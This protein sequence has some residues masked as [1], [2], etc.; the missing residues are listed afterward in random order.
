MKRAMALADLLPDLEIPRE[1]VVRGLVQDSRSVEPG[2]AFVAIG[3]FG[4][5]GL[6]FVGQARENGA[7]A[8]LFEPPI[9]SELQAP[10]DAIAVPGLRARLGAMADQF[11]ARPSRAL[12]MVGVTGTNGKTS[13]VQL[14]AQAWHVR[15]VRAGSIGTLGA[16]LYGEAVPTGFTTPLV[17]QLHALL[18]QLRDAG[19]DAVAMEVSSHALDQG[20]VDGV[21]FK[22][23]GVHEPD[24]RPSRLSRRR[25]TSLRRGEGE[26][27][28]MAGSCKPQC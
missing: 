13:T 16:G 17:L 23:G 22:V 2:D 14:L 6:G 7:S 15:G 11:H 21:H 28:R 1:I 8:I 26:A 12:R 10:A 4:A 5:H 25:W 9:P 18:A 27:V 19:A 24:P 20:R 3:G